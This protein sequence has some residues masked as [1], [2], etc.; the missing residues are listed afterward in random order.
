MGLKLL[1]LISLVSIY[2]ATEPAVGGIGLAE[3]AAS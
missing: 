3:K 1:K 2:E